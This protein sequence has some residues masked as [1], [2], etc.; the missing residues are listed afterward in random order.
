MIRAALWGV[1]VAFRRFDI[2]LAAS[3]G[4]LPPPLR[5][6]RPGP[7]MVPEGDPVFRH[8]S[9]ILSMTRAIPTPDDV[10]RS[11]GARFAAR[12]RQ[13][14]QWLAR[15]LPLHGMLQSQRKALS[16]GSSPQAATQSGSIRLHRDTLFRVQNDYV[17]PKLGTR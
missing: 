5:Y 2:R 1:G 7:G 9:G 3:A 16:T 12:A 14:R 17:A 13:P 10:S 11:A 8:N 4:L 6:P 15:L